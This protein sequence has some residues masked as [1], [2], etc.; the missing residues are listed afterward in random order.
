MSCLI[1]IFTVY[2]NSY[3]FIHFWRFKVKLFFFVISKDV[4][5]DLIITVDIL[6][7]SAYFMF[8]MKKYIWAWIHYYRIIH[9][10]FFKKKKI[11]TKEN[12]IIS[13]QCMN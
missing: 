10:D 13:F 6:C 11:A 8:H 12:K 2:S 5:L 3:I 1:R 9:S 7:S 4:L